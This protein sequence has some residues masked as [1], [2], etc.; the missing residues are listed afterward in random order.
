MS[1]TVKRRIYWLPS[2]LFV[3]LV[4]L[5]ICLGLYLHDDDRAARVSKARSV[6]QQVSNSLHVYSQERYQ[7]LINLMQNWPS[8]MPNP[9][10]WFNA[11][12]MAL[13]G[14]QGGYSALAYADKDGIIRWITRPK[15][16]KNTLLSDAIVGQPLMATGLKM[17]PSDELFANTLTYGLDRHYYLLA[18]RAVSPQ[19]PQ[20]GFVIAVFD[21]ERI[22]SSMMGELVGPQFNFE[23]ADQDAILLTSGQLDS[24]PTVVSPAPIGFMGRTWTLRMQSQV[25][26]VS[27]GLIIAV[28]GFVMSL[29]ACWVFHKQL[30]GAVKLSA[31]QQRY[32]TASEVSLDA[33]LIY[34]L[35]QKDFAL[36]EANLYAKRLF[37]GDIRAIR[38]DCLSEQLHKLGHGKIFTDVQR[39]F[40]T[41]IPYEDYLEIKTRL[42]A[43]QW[44]KIQVVKAENTLAITLRDVSERFNAQRALKQSEEKYR[45]LIDGMYRH[46]VYTKTLE[47]SFV[48]VSAGVEDILGYTVDEFCTKERQFVRQI[49]D[50][51]LQ[52]RHRIRNGEK[53]D[54][55]LVH[56]LGKDAEMRVIE[57]ADTPVMDENGKLIAVEGIARDV[58]KEQALQAEVYYQANHDQL[59]GLMN[60]YAFDSQLKELIVNVRN[61]QQRAVMCFIDMDRFKLVNDSCGHPAGDRLLTEVA[62]IFSRHVAE[63]DLLARIGGDEFCMIFFNQTLIEVKEKLDTLLKDIANYRFIYNDKLFFVGASIGVIEIDSANHTAAEFIKA[64]DNACYQ[65]KYLGRNR[66][67]VH[68]PSKEQQELDVA[69]SETLSLLQHA[70]EYDAFELYC[71]PI[72]PMSASDNGLHCEVLLRLESREGHMVSPGMFIPLAERHGLMNKV[73][74]WV[75]NKT[76]TLLENNA[77]QCEQ[78]AKIAINLSGIT[79][80]DEVLLRHIIQRVQNSSVPAEKLCFEIT[81]TTAVTNLSAAQ[82]FIQSLR[83]LGCHFALDDFGAGMSSFMYLK[84]LDVDYVK[85]DGSFVRNIARDQ[86]DLA[87]VTAINNI[88]HSMGKKTIAEFVVDEHTCDVLRALS[89]DYGQGFALGKPQPIMQLLDAQQ[90][91]LVLLSK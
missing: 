43:P 48:Y 70:I 27:P 67:Y 65:A 7:A 35:K 8:F 2:A 75:V 60:R 56:Y 25:S 9:T 78:L 17:Q 85:I 55:Y 61:G 71:Q 64:A 82:G 13:L 53:P 58:T 39:V 84:N 34:Q 90:T 28:I 46:F 54:P 15:D 32:K 24:G 68:E 83:A 33:I 41:D 6:G 38:H 51:T 88:A 37:A 16:V 50:E 26:G 3:V 29:A 1:E 36:V 73:D 4:A 91:R 74:W 59:T 5:F 14:M 87:T 10:D 86:I 45:R 52:I 49:P 57:F 81:E 63:K 77:K 66:Y 21:V 12:A 23:L 42:I 76:L 18:G 30:K 47:H 19:E 40:S 11:E 20:H 79:L 62:K 22:L 69:E 80:G 31:S 44:L 89:V 72:V